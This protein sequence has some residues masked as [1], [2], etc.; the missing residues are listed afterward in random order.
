MPYRSSKILVNAKVTAEITRPVSARVAAE[1]K[2]IWNLARFVNHQKQP[3]SR[4]RAMQLKGIVLKLGCL[5]GISRRDSA[6]E[7]TIK[8]IIRCMSS[9][10][11][12]R[13]CGALRPQAEGTRPE[14]RVELCQLGERSAC[15]SSRLGFC[16]SERPQPPVLTERLDARG[17]NA[18]GNQLSI[19]HGDT[20]ANGVRAPLEWLI[21]QLNRIFRRSCPC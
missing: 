18:R 20:K 9:C 5:S 17:G 13:V 21:D 2:S 1:R 10:I 14:P 15:A 8:M 4:K 6:S 19:A 3:I 16:S 7:N 12:I 11:M